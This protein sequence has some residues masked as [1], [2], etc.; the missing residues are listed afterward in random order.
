MPEKVEHCKKETL[1]ETS[2]TNPFSKLNNMP[3]SINCARVDGDCSVCDMN[4][5]GVCHQ[6]DSFDYLDYSDAD[7]GM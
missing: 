7:P 1:K 5:D 6:D 3:N 2:I 4:I